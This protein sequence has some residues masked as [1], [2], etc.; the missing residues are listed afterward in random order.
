MD[1]LDD[2]DRQLIGLLRADSRLP[3]VTLARR[4][5]VSRGTVQNRIDRLV[6][7][8][9]IVNFTLRLRGDVETG[10]IRAITSIELRSS[11]A[12]SVVAALR[13]M[14]DVAGIHSTNGRWDLLVSINCESL[15]HLDRLLADIR[16]IK[17]I[18]HSETSIL[19]ADLK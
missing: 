5:G 8:G 12:A 18:S 15:G 16:S 13:R 14:P 3:A 7:A 19:L 6:A 10:R 11:E 17:A 1:G 9:V 2:L 4:L